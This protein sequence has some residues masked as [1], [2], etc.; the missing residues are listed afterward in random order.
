MTLSVMGR[1]CAR[2]GPPRTAPRAFSVTLAEGLGAVGGWHRGQR[3][4]RKGRLRRGDRR[5]PQRLGAARAGEAFGPVALAHVLDADAAA[6]ARRMD[7]L[8]VADVDADVREGPAQRV[9][10]DQVARREFVALDG[11]EAGRVRLLVDAAGQ[12]EAEAG[13]EDVA[14][15]AAAVEALVAGAAAAVGHAEEV[16]RRDDHVA[17]LVLHAA[18]EA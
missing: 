11:D 2:P 8:A 15:E 10:E 12:H 17:G 6:G 1:D 9:E 5:G 18:D 3:W 13:F 14:R 4:Q 16:H 7:E